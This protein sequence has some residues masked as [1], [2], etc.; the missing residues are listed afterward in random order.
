MILR[1]YII[2]YLYLFYN[3]AVDMQMIPS[4]K[5]SVMSLR[6]FGDCWGQ[7]ASCKMGDLFVWT[8]F[9]P[10]KNFSLFEDF[11]ISGEVLQIL[12]YARHIDQWGFISAPHL[13]TS[14]WQWNCRYLFKR[15]RSVATEIRTPNIACG[16]NALTHS[17]T[18][19]A[20]MGE[21]SNTN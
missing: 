8:F 15:R 6:Y 12:I 10:L 19:A 9:V 5:K 20:K 13:Q 4:D 16:A 11:T 3:G 7:W 18:A 17:A 21:A 14:V 2:V 1:S